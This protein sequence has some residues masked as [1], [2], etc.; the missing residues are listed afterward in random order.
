MA[1]LGPGTWPKREIPAEKERL[2]QSGGQSGEGAHSARGRDAARGDTRCGAGGEE[3]PRAHAA[4]NRNTV[5]E[6][7]R[8]R[9]EGTPTGAPCRGL[10]TLAAATQGTGSRRAL[11]RDVHANRSGHYSCELS[12]QKYSLKSICRCGHCQGERP[13]REGWGGTANGALTAGNGGGGEALPGGAHRRVER[14]R[15]TTGAAPLQ[16]EGHPLAG[17]LEQEE[18][19]TG[20]GR[21]DS[22]SLVSSLVRA[23]WRP[24]SELLPAPS[25]PRPLL[26]SCRCR[27]LWLRLS[28]SHELTAPNGLQLPRSS[29]SSS[30]FQASERT[31]HS[32]SPPPV[33]TLPPP[34]L[35]ALAGSPEHWGVCLLAHTPWGRVSVLTH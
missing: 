6:H 14:G 16:R 24:V 10:G 13:L 11:L 17:R 30:R 34:T 5:P 7:S 4:G 28:L 12:L 9:G 27:F 25:H 19:G 35:P 3:C 8:C 20:P 21:A 22:V 1:G 15:R 32:A 31:A 23:G 18:R 29:N 26:P 33:S 2:P